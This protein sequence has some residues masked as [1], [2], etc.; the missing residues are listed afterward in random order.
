M[1]NLFAKILLVATSLSPVLIAI[2]VR[3]VDGGE[4]SSITILWVLAALLL[5]FLCGFLL[6]YAAGNAEKHSL[7]VTDFD[8]RDHE[9]LTF[10]FIY[11]LPFLQSEPMTL[12]GNLIT[13]AFITFIIVVAIAQA[14]AFH[15][16]PVMRLFYGYRFYIVKDNRRMTSLLISKYDLQIPGVRIESVRIA[17]NVYLQTGVSDD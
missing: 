5:V 2:A 9:V 15:F 8:R 7:C 14:E 12:S 17:K 11:L 13:I 16:N 10:L 4:Y 3:Q 1:L 6:K